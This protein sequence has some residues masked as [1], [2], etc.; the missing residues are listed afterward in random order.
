MELRYFGI[1]ISVFGGEAV[2]YGIKTDGNADNDGG[3]GER[4][5]ERREER[6]NKREKK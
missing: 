5:E 3:Y 6:G 4:I 1:V 2:V